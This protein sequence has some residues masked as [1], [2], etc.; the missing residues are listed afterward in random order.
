MI[1][2]FALP[3]AMLAATPVF[4]QSAPAPEASAAAPARSN[5]MRDRLQQVHDRLGITPAQQPQWD[6]VVAALRDNAVALRANPAGAAVRSGSLDAVAEL[7]AASDLARARADA[8][9]RMVPPVE[10]LYASLSPE[11]QH[12][13]DQVLDQ[14]MHGRRAKRG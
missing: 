6:A 3:L 2:R 14:A 1:Y 7:R 4:A 12:T 10:A 9:A 5:A 13:A 8:L 11:Q